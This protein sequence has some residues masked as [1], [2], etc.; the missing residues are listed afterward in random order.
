MIRY[1]WFDAAGVLFHVVAQRLGQEISRDFGIPVMGVV[2]A[3]RKVQN[4][5]ETG[6]G[7]RFWHD[8]AAELGID[9]SPE[10][11]EKRYRSSVLP[12]SGML[13]LLAS[14]QG[15]YSLVLANNEARLTDSI[16]NE[17]VGHFRYFDHVCS[18]WKIGVRKPSKEYFLKVLDIIGASPQECVFVDDM[19]KNLDMASSVGIHTILFRDAGQLKKDL[20]KIGVR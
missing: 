2:A 10:A 12:V 18:S 9:C 20:E 6:D 15:R 13:E 8:L 11:L 16:R 5:H 7:S 1:V 17:L 19:Q 3:W 14:L 4:E